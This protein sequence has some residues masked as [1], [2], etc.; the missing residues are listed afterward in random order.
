M[1][2]KTIKI[3]AREVIIFT[4]YLLITS[5]TLFIIWLN[6]YN[7]SKNEAEIIRSRI[8]LNRQLLASFIVNPEKGEVVDFTEVEDITPNFDSNKSKMIPS[9]EEFEFYNTVSQKY[10]IGTLSEF[11]IKIQYPKKR[12]A[13]YNQLVHDRYDPGTYNQFLKK[14]GFVTSGSLLERK[15]TNIEEVMNAGPNKPIRAYLN[16]WI[17]TYDKYL[18]EINVKSSMELT[19]LCIQLVFIFSL[20]FYPLRFLIIAIIWAI[21][22]LR[23]K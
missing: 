19:H 7:K 21:K 11:L 16:R 4:I 22:I 10:D 17:N 18:S 20:F 14:L 15:S 5:G 3:I 23:A 2:S 1:T 13:L 9:F 6:N 12:L 8:Q